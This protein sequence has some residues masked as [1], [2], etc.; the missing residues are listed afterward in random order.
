[1]SMW[2]E[3]KEFAVKGNAIDLAVGVVIG[4]AFGN[5]V[6]SLVKD[7]IMP[8]IGVLTGGLDFSERFFVLKSAPGAATFSTPAEA[9]KAGAV[10]LNYGSFITLVINFLIVAFCIFILVKALNKMKRQPEKQAEP[11]SKECPYCTMT[12]GIKAR[13]CPHCTSDLT[14]V[15][16]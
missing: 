11:V 7:V 5:I 13:R 4:A 2:K 3:F 9:V 6:N 8:P 14:Q 15:A 1:M 16:T 10:T 12:V